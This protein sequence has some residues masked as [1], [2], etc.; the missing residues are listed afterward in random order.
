MLLQQHTALL[1]RRALAILALAAA[2]LALS[3]CSKPAEVAA[4]PKPVRVQQVALAAAEQEESY[5]GA[6]HARVESD[7][8]F[9]V[10]G[11]VVRRAVEVGQRVRAGDLLA[12]LDPQDYALALAAAANQEQAAAAEAAQAAAD[13]RRFNRL[14]EQGFVSE[15]EAQRYRSRATATSERLDQA[16]HETELARNRAAYAALRAPFDGIVMATQ[17]EVGQ[18]VSAGQPVVTLAGLGDREIVVDIPESRLPQAKRKS[19]FATLWVANAHRFA[20]SLRELSP[21]ASAATRTYRARY[22]VGRD[23]P[24]MELGMTATVWIDS[25][26]GD[27]PARTARLPASALHHREGAPAV[28][29]VPAAGGAPVLTPVQVVRYGADEVQV[30]G[31][32][33]GELVVVA[34]V[35]TLYPQMHVVAIDADGRQIAPRNTN[36]VT[37]TAAPAIPGAAGSQPR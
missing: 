10:G 4:P 37:A 26:S 35:Q 7:V 18:V 12:Q 31:V 17:A 34:G 32:R 36:V 2:A 11:K 21:V 29:V 28:W 27:A 33:D 15:A 8:A 6:V 1:P 19:A 22:Q 9:R 3:A 23:A 24:P 25:E 13:A 14:A 30:S 5:T 16:R 20:V